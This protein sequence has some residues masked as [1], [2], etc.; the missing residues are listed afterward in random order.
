M[1]RIF[2][3]TEHP[4]KLSLQTRSTSSQ[5]LQSL[6]PKKLS[7]MAAAANTAPIRSFPK[8]RATTTLIDACWAGLHHAMTHSK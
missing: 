2:T 6:G 4:T 3:F 5:M 7:S 1:H 8:R